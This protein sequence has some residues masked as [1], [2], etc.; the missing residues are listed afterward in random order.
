LIAVV[1]G[2]AGFIGSHLC[3]LLVGRGW[4]VIAIDNFLTGR[5]SNIAALER[6]DS[7]E[8]VEADVSKPLPEQ[9]LDS[10]A[11]V[12]FHLASPASPGKSP[13]SYM[14]LPFETLRAGSC[15][16][17]TLLDYAKARRAVF[18]LASTSEVYGD[19]EVSPQPESYWGNVNP[20]GPRAVYDEAKRFAEALSSAYAR[21]FGLDVKIARI[22]NTYGPKMRPDDGRV[23]SN[24]VVQALTGRPL[25]VYGDGSQT[26]SFCYIDDMVK[27]LVRLA[28][29]DL[30]GP[31]NLGNPS[32]FRIIEL[33]ELV[34]QLVPDA[35]EITY[36]PLPPDDPKQRRPDISLA[37]ERLG[38]EP[39][40]PLAEGLKKTIEWY[41]A[42]LAL[43]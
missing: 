32:E 15:G 14:S 20:V 5:R 39:K 6:S 38:W 21:E 18:V 26:R 8:I 27:G 42:E 31:C 29:S 43:A 37:T 33:A 19:P 35:P 36:E 17:W 11:D 4:K 41:R 7:F 2:G 34:R 30:N 24:M 40:V 1:S 12:V 10:P 28:E 3:E 23:V 22:F 13:Y 9:V 25:T 16:T